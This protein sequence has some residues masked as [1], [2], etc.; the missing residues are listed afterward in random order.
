MPQDQSLIRASGAIVYNWKAANT[1]LGN[2]ERLAVRVSGLR[3]CKL[4][5]YVCSR[6]K[7]LLPRAPNTGAP[8]LDLR[9]LKTTTLRTQEVEVSG[10]WIL[11]FRQ[12]VGVEQGSRM[13]RC[14]HAG[15]LQDIL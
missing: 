8:R 3:V 12:D 2:T 15:L 7:I 13:L 6:F 4:Q 9:K 1:N 10:L 5:V 11:Q 14:A